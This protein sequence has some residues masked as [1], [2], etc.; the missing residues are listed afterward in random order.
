M[1]ITDRLTHFSFSI[2]QLDL[3]ILLDILLII[4]QVLSWQI[5]NIL[6]II[7]QVL[8]WQIVNILLYP[9]QINFTHFQFTANKV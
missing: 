4:F 7:F 9:L 2:M 3:I 1:V 6:L 5:V 8:S